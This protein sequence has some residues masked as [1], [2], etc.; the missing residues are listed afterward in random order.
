VSDAPDPFD[1]IKA[2]WNPLGL[3]MGS[4]AAPT[5][6]LGEID[7][8]IADLKLVENWL[9]MNLAMLRMSVQALEMQRMAIA[10][11]QSGFSPPGGKAAQG[12]NPA[13]GGN[14]EQAGESQ[15]PGGGA[16]AS[17]PAF[18][19]WLKMM[20]AAMKGAEPPVKPPRSK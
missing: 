13:Q 1:F 20:Q 14:A 12:N 10:A 16:P 4:M 18:E 9:N 19:A 2:F 5:L 8:R 6:D 15:T 3:P 7:K 17:N 11:M